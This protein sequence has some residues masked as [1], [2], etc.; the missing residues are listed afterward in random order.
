VVGNLRIT[1]PVDAGDL[2]GDPLAVIVVCAASTH[3]ADNRAGRGLGQ[4]PKML[5]L[6]AEESYRHLRAAS[7]TI[8]MLRSARWIDAENSRVA[9]LSS[10]AF[11]VAGTPRALQ[12]IPD[13][14]GGTWLS[15]I[16]ALL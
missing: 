14:L 3:R 12:P 2:F 5:G 1:D 7:S 9:V 8:E 10:V 4:S 15:L 13:F 11:T 16:T 6:L